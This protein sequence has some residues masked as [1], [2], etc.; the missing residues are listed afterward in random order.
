[1]I[2]VYCSY[3][4]KSHKETPYYIQLIHINK[5]SIYCIPTMYLVEGLVSLRVGTIEEDFK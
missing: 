3:I 5:K 2:K 1:M 4:W